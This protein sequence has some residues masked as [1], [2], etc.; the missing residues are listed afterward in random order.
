[1]R[2]ILVFACPV[3]ALFFIDAP[4]FSSDPR[5]SFFQR[6]PNADLGVLKSEK[7]IW[8]G[9]D[10]R[11]RETVREKR[12]MLNERS[13]E[14]Y[15]E[16]QVPYEPGKQVLSILDA[17]TTSPDGK[18]LSVEKNAMKDSHPYA[19]YPAYDRTMVKT[20]TF[21]GTSPGALTEYAFSLQSDRVML[22]GAF[23]DSFMMHRIQPSLSASYTLHLSPGL[24]LKY[25]VL[26]PDK[27]L[28]VSFTSGKEGENSVLRWST[29]NFGHV[30]Y[31]PGMP[32]WGDLLPRLLLSTA[33]DWSQCA[34][35]FLRLNGKN[36]EPTPVIKELAEKLTRGLTTP[37]DKTRAIYHWVVG[38]I[39]YVYVSMGFAGYET[40]SAEEILRDRYGDCKGGSSLLLALLKAAGIPAC[41]AFLATNDQPKVVEDIPSM[42]QFNHC[43]V[44]V[45]QN[46]KEWLFLDSVGKTTRFGTLPS[47]DQGVKALVLDS[48]KPIFVSIPISN[49]RTEFSEEEREV[50]LDEKGDALV[51][52]RRRFGGSEESGERGFYQARSP[53]QIKI[54]FQ[55][56]ALQY[57]AG[58][59]LLDFSLGDPR[60][61]EKPFSCR[62]R[63][64][65]RE[66]AIR[67]GD[68]LVF[69][70]PG[71]STGMYL[72]D[73]TERIHPV[74]AENGKYLERARIT[75]PV[76]YRVRY[77]P[78]P[79]HLDSP[80]VSFKGNYRLE[81]NV[82]LFEALMEYKAADLAVADYRKTR[83]L[84]LKRARFG[85]EMIVFEKRR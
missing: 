65:A 74:K 30:R 35:W 39:R 26:N 59:E 32:P 11:Y 1:M 44:A 25:R 48:K 4:A 54:S 62:F 46:Q 64:R 41:Y 75:V 68:I 61:L 16:V 17:M 2:R 10:G 47:M 9:N 79:L 38:N 23:A 73:P 45:K 5:T 80:F 57:A 56:E 37:S 7:E 34:D 53:E 31:E 84:Y 36:T 85:K 72:F 42:Y 67:A 69:R 76:G 29:Q 83:E 63:Y 70:V 12:E 77:L 51:S 52:V 22:D 15:S 78:K 43:I 14:R 27:N 6:F 8:V 3:L 82:V 60:N 24:N 49:G 50:S 21:P 40:Q 33:S 20:F 58:S 55:K 13:K 71:F 81:G 28:P 66:N 18:V 19:D